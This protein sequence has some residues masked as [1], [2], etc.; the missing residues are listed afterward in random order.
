MHVAKFQTAFRIPLRLKPTLTKKLS[1]RKEDCAMRLLYGCRE[2]F[3]ESLSTPT[4]TFREIL[5]ALGLI[6]L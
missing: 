4:A 1:Y 6:H 3:R 5:W 2:N